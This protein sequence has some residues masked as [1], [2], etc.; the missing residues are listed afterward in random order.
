MI[1]DLDVLTIVA[2]VIPMTAEGMVT[3]AHSISA[4][5]ECLTPVIMFLLCVAAPTITGQATAFRGS[6]PERA[7]QSLQV[8]HGKRP[9]IRLVSFVLGRLTLQREEPTCFKPAAK[10]QKTRICD[11]TVLMVP[12]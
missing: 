10:Q 11:F 7:M 6:M 12:L 8:V 3:Y 4:K 9:L 1:R 5:W 2:V